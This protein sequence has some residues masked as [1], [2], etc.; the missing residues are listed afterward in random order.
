MFKVLRDV[1][2]YKLIVFMF[3]VLRSHKGDAADI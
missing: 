1:T 2:N 3:K